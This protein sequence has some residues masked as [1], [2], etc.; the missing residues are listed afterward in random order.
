MQYNTVRLE[1]TGCHV[2]GM[3]ELKEK[4]KKTIPVKPRPTASIKTVLQRVD[5]AS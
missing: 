2:D 1:S 3:L 4:K 5:K